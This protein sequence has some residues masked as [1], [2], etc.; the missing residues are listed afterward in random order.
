MKNTGILIVL[1]FVLGVSACIGTKK[2]N[3]TI[4]ITEKVPTEEMSMKHEMEGMDDGRISLGLNAMQKEHQLIN[5]RSHLVAIQT[6]I[7]LLA[8]DNYEKASEVAYT[9]LGSTT[10]MRMMCASFGNKQFETLGLNF[11]KSADEMSE[12]LK[13]KDKVKS[14]EALSNT[15]NYCIACHA[16]YRQ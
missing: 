15:M 7:G 1:I 6:I 9:Q 3:E 14:L 13:T 10:E 4:E 12:I 8:K 2:Q 16:T 5:M 11:H